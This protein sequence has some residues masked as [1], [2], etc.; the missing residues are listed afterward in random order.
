MSDHFTFFKSY[1]E[2]VKELDAETKAEYFDALFEYALENIE[3][4]FVS[5]VAKAVFTAIKPNIDKSKA[6]QSAGKAGGKQ[7][8]ATGNQ[9]AIKNEANQSKTNQKQS[10]KE[11]DKEKDKEI[12]KSEF[13]FGIFTSEQFQLISSYRSKIKKP[14]KTQQAITGLSNAFE[15]CIN[16]GY[17]FQNLFGLMQEKQWQ[18]LKLEWVQKEIPIVSPMGSGK[19]IGGYYV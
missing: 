4:D 18:S 19:M 1:Y 8:K 10:D 9:N 13:D 14:F 6:R 5:P 2:S 16:A 12:Y 7:S 3:H 15:Q 17:T 11:K